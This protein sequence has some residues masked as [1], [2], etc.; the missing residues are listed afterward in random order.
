MTNSWHVAGVQYSYQRLAE[1]MAVTSLAH[2]FQDAPYVHQNLANQIGWIS[3]LVFFK[4]FSNVSK[5]NVFCTNQALVQNMSFTGHHQAHPFCP[6]V[7]VCLHL[8]QRN[9]TILVPIYLKQPWAMLYH[10]VT[11][12]NMKKAFISLHVWIFRHNYFKDF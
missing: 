6:V 7:L 9:V 4:H 10:Y 2:M 5:L 1:H 11:C 8:A 12:L 3:D